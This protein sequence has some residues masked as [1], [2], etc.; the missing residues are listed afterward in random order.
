[1]IANW[2]KEKHSRE[3]SLQYIISFL[4]FA[5]ATMPLRV[6]KLL[7][8]DSLINKKLLTTK[9]IIEFLQYNLCFSLN[10]ERPLQ[11]VKIRWTKY[12]KKY[13]DW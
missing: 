6:K 13:N 10:H 9:H 3:N 2:L 7:T 12:V 11:R 4:Q 8:N 1:M 5:A